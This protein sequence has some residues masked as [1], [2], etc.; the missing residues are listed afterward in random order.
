MGFIPYDRNQFDMLGYSLDDF[1]PQDA[2]CRYIVELVARLDLDP[3]REYYST[4][5]ADSFDP[6]LMLAIWFFSYSEGESSTRR[7]KEKCYRDMHYIYVSANLRPDHT[8]LSRFRK[9]HLDLMSDYFVQLVHIAQAEGISDFSEIST[10]GS[11][12]Q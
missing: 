10:D 5:G 3:L 11:R 9:T 2:K 8:S 6:A 12:P 1:V 4:Q 7:I